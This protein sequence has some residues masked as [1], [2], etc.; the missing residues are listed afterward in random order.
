MRV[1]S[2]PHD[3][4]PSIVDRAGV[5]PGAPV[6]D[7]HERALAGAVLA[8]EGVHLAGLE[9]ERDAPGGLHATEGDG[10]V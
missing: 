1:G 10:D 8:D 5:G 3:G 2:R 4:C 9:I 6:D 7:A